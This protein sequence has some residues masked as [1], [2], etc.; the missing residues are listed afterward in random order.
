MGTAGLTYSGRTTAT[1]RATELTLSDVA[2]SGSTRSTLR[3]RSGVGPRSRYHAHRPRRA[4]L[5][6]QAMAAGLVLFFGWLAVV[7]LWTL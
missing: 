3:P 5:F 2:R 1:L 4:S 6:V 7:W